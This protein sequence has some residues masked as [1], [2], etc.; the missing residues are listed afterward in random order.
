M[1]TGGTVQRHRRLSLRVKARLST[2][3]PIRDAATGERY[4]R[5]SEETCANISRSG[6]FVATHQPIERGCRVML[7]IE[8]PGGEGLETLAQV[9]WS[10]TTLVRPGSAARSEEQSGLGIE[11]IEAAP[12]QIAKLEKYLSA[13]LPRT[14]APQ[15]SGVDRHRGPSF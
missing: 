1:K 9:V 8:L 10:R 12:D 11:F 13:S 15:Q 2:I 5:S 7:E 3:D 4:F 14:P 6:A